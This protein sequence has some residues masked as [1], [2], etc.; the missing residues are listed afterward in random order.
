MYIYLYHTYAMCSIFPV[1]LVYIYIYRRLPSRHGNVSR[2]FRAWRIPSGNSGIASRHG[3][4]WNITNVTDSVTSHHRAKPIMD[5][6]GT[7]AL[8]CC[9][10]ASRRVVSLP[11]ISWLS[12]KGTPALITANHKESQSITWIT[13]HHGHHGV[14]HGS[15]RSGANHERS[16]HR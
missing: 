14:R 13:E 1:V 3:T 11:R 9:H 8:E 7:D 15:S 5:N 10:G 2:T 6:H 4:S 16:Q 12:D